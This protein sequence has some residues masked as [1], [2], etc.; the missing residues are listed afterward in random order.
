MSCSIDGCRVSDFEQIVSPVSVAHF[1]Q[2]KLSRLLIK[3]L[4]NLDFHVRNCDS[5]E[6]L[7]ADFMLEREILMGHECTSLVPACDHV[8]VGLLIQKGGTKIQRNIRCNILVGADGARSTVRKL[9]G[10]NMKGQR[11]LQKLISVHFLSEDLG[12]Y[13]LHHRPGML[14]FIYNPEAIGVLVAHDLSQGEFVMQVPFYPPQQSP[15]DFSPKKLLRNL[16]HVIIELYLWEMRLTVF[17][18]PVV[19]D[20]QDWRQFKRVY[21]SHYPPTSMGCESNDTLPTPTFLFVRLL[22]ASLSLCP[23]F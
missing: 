12:Q 3:R 10:I 7:N 9:V 21:L 1:S 5:P 17:L 19:L 11:D 13:L 22:H 2:Y 8:K 18:R 4:E 6:V 23:T 14:F 16:S 20:V 15:E